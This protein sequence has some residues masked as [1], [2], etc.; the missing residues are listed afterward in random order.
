MEDNLFFFKYKMDRI[1]C[2]FYLLNNI[3][4]ISL[5]TEAEFKN[6]IF[7]SWLGTQGEQWTKLVFLEIS[8]TSMLASSWKHP[9]I[10][11]QNQNIGTESSRQ[12]S[13][14]GVIVN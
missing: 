12:P 3:S 5:L 13:L 2:P 7:E 10:E 14:L 1:L 8:L 4:D 9:A 6:L 11:C